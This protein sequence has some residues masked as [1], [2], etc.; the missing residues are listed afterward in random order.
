MDQVSLI[1]RLPTI[2][3]AYDRTLLI[4]SHAGS[5]WG[6]PRVKE[7]EIARNSWQS[8][9]LTA[10]DDTIIVSET[11]HKLRSIGATGCLVIAIAD[12][13]RQVGAVVHTY[14]AEL[15]AAPLKFAIEALNGRPQDM[16][17]GISGV[18]CSFTGGKED[19]IRAQIAAGIG[20]S[21][22][23]IY[24]QMGKKGDIAIDFQH[25]TIGSPDENIFSAR[26]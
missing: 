24:N 5:G 16:R 25:R 13:T 10:P 26:F 8:L 2:R 7:M 20:Q 23:I 3:R 18:I 11:P 22:R 17:I 9:E 14:V 15:F 21:G 6:A 4:T 1:P 19:T 12:V